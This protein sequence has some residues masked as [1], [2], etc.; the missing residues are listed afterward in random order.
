VRC[1]TSRVNVVIQHEER[2]Q[3]P[4]PLD[5]VEAAPLL[6]VRETRAAP[7]RGSTERRARPSTQHSVAH[8]SDDQ[9]ECLW[10]P[11]GAAAQQ[12]RRR[13]VAG[14]IVPAVIVRGFILS[15]ELSRAGSGLAPLPRNV[16]RLRVPRHPRAASAAR[17]ASRGVAWS[18]AQLSY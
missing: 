13:V 6:S 17:E 1:R 12:G 3:A 11:S 10:V 7:L 9:Q 5:V 18:Q 15:L 2:A 16:K 8:C 14:P 4:A